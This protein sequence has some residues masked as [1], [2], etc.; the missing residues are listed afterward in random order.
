MRQ[1]WWQGLF[2]VGMALCLCGCTSWWTTNSQPVQERVLIDPGHGGMD[3]GTQAEDGTLEKHLNLD[4]S[5]SL[6]DMLA[7]CGFPV[8][9]T[10]SSDVSIHDPAANSVREKKVSDMRNRLALYEAAGLV[11]SVHQNHFSQEKYAGATVYFSGNHPDSQ[12][13]GTCVR[14]ELLRLLQPD[15]TR[16]MKKATD[17]IYLLYYT[18]RPAILV[19]CGFLSN[20]AEREQL[21][22]KEYRQQM[23]FAILGGYLSFLSQK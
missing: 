4:I 15:N 11:I 5:L 16:V 13:L 23:A 19:E 21:K 22:T 6:R 8:E 18:N 10:R 20:Y 3:G 17:G 7:V 12:K 9:M 1:R 14:E 2:C